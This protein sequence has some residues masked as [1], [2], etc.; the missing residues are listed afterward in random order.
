VLQREW[1][2]FMV[3]DCG[4]LWELQVTVMEM[5][6]VMSRLEHS[7]TTSQHN[8]T[9]ICRSGCCCSHIRSV[10]FTAKTDTHCCWF[11]SV[12]ERMLYYA[13]RASFN[14]FLRSLQSSH[15]GGDIHTSSHQG[16][17]T[18]GGSQSRA[19][20]PQYVP[21]CLKLN[22]RVGRIP[23]G[24]ITLLYCSRMLKFTCSIKCHTSHLEQV[25]FK[26]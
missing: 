21:S 26:N 5:Y 20:L 23:I 1:K 6:Y 4:E 16:Q 15:C 13:A 19:R 25:I 18:A 24:Y 2:Q 12:H 11:S 10:W 3:L 17:Q 8:V 9:G 7:V 22:P 14:V